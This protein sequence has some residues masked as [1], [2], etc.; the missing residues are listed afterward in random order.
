MA[1]G[2]FASTEYCCCLVFILSFLPYFFVF[3][4]HFLSMLQLDTCIISHPFFFSLVSY[5]LPLVFIFK[6][7]SLHFFIFS[8]FS[9]LFITVYLA[10]LLSSCMPSILHQ[11]YYG[12]YARVQVMASLKYSKYPHSIQQCCHLTS[13][14]T[15]SDFHFFHP[16]HSDFVGSVP[17]TSITLSISFTLI[18]HTISDF[19]FKVEIFVQFLMFNFAVVLT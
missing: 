6:F 17:N 11:L 14:P 8:H 7:S 16:R 10:Y 13:I 15:F 1:L 5:S 19:S 12:A 4:F 3:S 18:F 9:M 2:N